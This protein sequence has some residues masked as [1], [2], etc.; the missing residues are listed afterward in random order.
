MNSLVLKYKDLVK[1]LYSNSI[2]ITFT[3]TPGTDRH[4][5]L[6]DWPAVISQVTTLNYEADY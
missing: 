1:H 2:N 4:F 3:V 5:K 6:I